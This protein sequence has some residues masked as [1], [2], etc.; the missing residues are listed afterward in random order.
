MTE[1]NKLTKILTKIKIK[2]P[3]MLLV[4]S[5]FGAFLL[6]YASQKTPQNHLRQ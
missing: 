3:N 6:R 2:E 5:G 4:A 1:D